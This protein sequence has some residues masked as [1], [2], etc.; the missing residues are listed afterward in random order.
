M[1][2]LTGQQI[3]D[4]YPGLLNLNVATTGVTSTPQ[5]ITDGIGNDTGSRIG[6]NFFSAPNV[7]GTNNPTQWIPDYGGIGISSTVVP[8]PAANQQ[9]KIVARLFYDPGIWSYSAITYSIFSASTTTDTVDVAFY[10]TQYYP[11]VGVVP[12]QLIMSGISIPTNSIGTFLNTT[13]PS[14]LSF[15][16]TGGG[17]Y[18]MLFKVSNSGVTPTVRFNG[19]VST[20]QTTIGFYQQL[21][22]FVRDRQGTNLV[23]ALGTNGPQNLYIIDTGTTFQTT[24]SL[25]QVNINTSINAYNMGFA[26]KCA[27]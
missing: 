19:P 15:S 22:G 14:T 7:V 1:A 20:S 5:A 18:Y 12:Y 2:N 26:L 27:K 11:T 3:K 23:Q 4:T 6:T 8:A 9:N 25:N 24:Y 21:G 17:L 10:S 16:G 13:L